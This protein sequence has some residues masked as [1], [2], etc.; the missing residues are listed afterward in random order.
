MKNEVK[1]YQTSVVSNEISLVDLLRV[2]IKRKNT[3]LTVFFLFSLGGIVLAIILP[4]QYQY[5]TTIEIGT[6]VVK[7]E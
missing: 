6:T 5:T 2:L 3:L 4:K 1:S 7:D